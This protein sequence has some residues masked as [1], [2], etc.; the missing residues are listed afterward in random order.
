MSTKKNFQCNEIILR[1]LLLQTDSFKT[2]NGRMEEIPVAPAGT[3]TLNNSMD[4][5]HTNLYCV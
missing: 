3:P 4:E 2:M 5:K 1:Y